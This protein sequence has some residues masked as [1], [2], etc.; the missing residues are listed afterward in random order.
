M[1]ANERRQYEPGL[2]GGR[3]TA[4]P[5]VVNGDY[6]AVARTSSLGAASLLDPQQ[7]SRSFAQDSDALGVAEAWRTED[8]VDGR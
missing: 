8:M 3:L 5:F 2:W 6:L 7:V 1:S 4:A